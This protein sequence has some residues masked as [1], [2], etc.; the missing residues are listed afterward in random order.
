MAE[1][2]APAG[3]QEA[4]EAALAAGADA[5]YLALEKYGARAYAPNFTEETL[6]TALEQ[7]HLADVK[8]YAAMNTILFEGEVE[9]AFQQAVRLYEM[10]IDALIVQDLGLMHLLHE[11]LPELEVHASTQLSVTSPEEIERLKQLGIKRVVLAREC[12]L[13]QIEAAA[14]TGMEVEVFVHG[15]LCISYSGQCQ[16]SAVRHGRSGNRGQCAQACRMEYELLKDGKPVKTDGPFLLSPRDIS[17]VKDIEALEK[18]GVASLKI[19]GR[20]KSPAYVYSAVKAVKA[21]GKLSKAEQLDLMKTFSRTFSRG[22]LRQAYG[23]SLLDP[24]FNSHRGIEVGEVIAADRNRVTIRLHA[25]IDQGDGL[26]F[27][28]AG[29]QEGCRINFLY[30]RKGKLI[31][32]GKAGDVVQADM[33]AY[34]PKGAMV[35]QT[36]SARLESDVARSVQQA[37]PQAKLRGSLVCKAAGEDIEF[38]IWDPTHS[39]SVS[40]PSQKAQKRAMDENEIRRVLEA[41]GNEW[42]TFEKLDVRVPADLFVSVK[43]LKQLRRQALEQLKEARLQ[44]PKANVRPY[45]FHP[46]KKELSGLY[47][48]IRKPEQL[49]DAVCFSEFPIAGA[50]SKGMLGK[51]GGLVTANLQEG[52]ILGGMNITNSYGAAAA[53]AL[54]YEGVVLSEEL[55]Q[56]NLEALARAFSSRYGFDI[57]ALAPVYMRRRLMVMEHCPVN[58]AL[59]DGTRKHCALCRQSHFE[60]KGLDGKKVW[61]SGNPACQ[62]ELYDQQVQDRTDWIS[63]LQ[64]AGI[65]GFLGVLTDENALEAA[66]VSKRLQS[67]ID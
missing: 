67:A 40:C 64:E 50:A 29:G 55:D 14:A 53:L 47:M 10:G 7:A 46:E 1:V 56:E 4:F 44:L 41:T 61:L 52:K 58:S 16:F 34:V 19:E 21:K 54:G 5:V 24:A 38:K 36:I 20:M 13:E 63:R 17:N 25:P 28:W 3:S 33:K 48:E 23:K 31:S 42:G 30:D 26:R 32:Q 60:L 65:H 11:R 57:P 59:K 49:C 18:A 45:D 22:H 15:A 43:E 12:S 66:E 37:H 62:M 35:R 27:E 51:S 9:D 39:V 6:K 2:L 8:V